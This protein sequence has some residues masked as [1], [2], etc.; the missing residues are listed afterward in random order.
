VAYTKATYGANANTPSNMAAS[1]ELLTG[2][3][4]TAEAALTE[5]RTL[6]SQSKVLTEAI[7]EGNTG[8]L[9]TYINTNIL[10]PIASLMTRLGLEMPAANDPV[11][12]MQILQ[13]DATRLAA[14]ATTASEQRAVQALNI[15]SSVEPN[16]DLTKRAN[17]SIM[18]TKLVDNQAEI[19]RAA[20]YGYYQ[21]RTGGLLQGAQESFN[22]LYAQIYAAEHTQLMKLF[23]MADQDPLV[24][25]LMK[26]AASGAPFSDV[27][28][29]LTE[30]L[31]KDISPALA[32]IITGGT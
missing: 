25:Q 12:Q 2:T 26:I 18:A 24:T 19:D 8:A 9:N 16:V 13:K 30:I 28:G 5:R 31:G 29:L 11:S 3:Q 6:R 23:E 4:A 14:A 7:A 1:G 17:A 22:N 20:Y 15:L 10:A 27:Q 21:S 32:R